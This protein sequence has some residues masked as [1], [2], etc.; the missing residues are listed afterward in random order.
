V[1]LFAFSWYQGCWLTYVIGSESTD[2]R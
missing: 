2:R 1:G